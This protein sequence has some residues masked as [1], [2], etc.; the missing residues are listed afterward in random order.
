MIQTIVR[1]CQRCHRP[2]PHPVTILRSPVSPGAV[3]RMAEVCPLCYMQLLAWLH[4][5]LEVVRTHELP[6]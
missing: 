5:N 6:R 4:E 1:T 2:T 3:R